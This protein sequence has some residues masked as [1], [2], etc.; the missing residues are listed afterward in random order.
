[1]S[2]HI[3]KKYYSKSE[4]I[5]KAR[6]YCAYQERCQSE[7]RSKLL[8]WGQ[9]GLALEE[10]ISDLITDD[11]INEERFACAY[12]RGKFRLKKWG[13]QKIKHE[14]KQRNISEYCIRKALNQIEQHD[15]KQALKDILTKKLK[16]LKDHNP[17]SRKH[18]LIAFA[19]RK[20]YSADLVYS[21][22]NNETL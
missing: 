2:E 15:I 20:G 21:V 1:M 8:E 18:K 22:V 9:R 13:T 12:A 5:E 10:I 11:F 7:V 14:L 16:T 17:L 19:I 3:Q 4:A 6:R